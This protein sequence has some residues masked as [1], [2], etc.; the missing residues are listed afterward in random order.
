MPWIAAR[1]D[2]LDVAL[3]GTDNPQA[4]NGRLNILLLIGIVAGIARERQRRSYRFR[5]ERRPNLNPKQ[6]RRDV[7]DLGE[8]LFQEILFY[9]V[10]MSG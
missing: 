7:I 1:V 8:V 2:D 10:C 6:A 9:I 3:F 5:G 4:Y